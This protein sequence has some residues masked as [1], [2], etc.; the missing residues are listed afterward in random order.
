[1]TSTISNTSLTITRVQLQRIRTEIL[2]LL[3]KRYPRYLKASDLHAITRLD[4]GRQTILREI[5]YLDEIGFV[6]T[7]PNDRVRIRA[8]GR[9]FLLG[10]IEAKG[11]LNP[12]MLDSVGEPR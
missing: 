5:Q 3:N 8:L 12:A 11:L 9:D 6:K 7:K 4:C 1:M 10:I 2:V